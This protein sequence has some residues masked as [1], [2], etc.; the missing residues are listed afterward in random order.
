MVAHLETGYGQPDLLHDSDALVSEDPS[1]RHGGHVAL[2]DVEIGAADRGRRDADDGVRGVFDL[3]PR[4]VLPGA[5]PGPVKDESLHVHDFGARDFACLD[6]GFGCS[7]ERLWSN[8]AARDRDA[9]TLGGRHR[10]RGPA[11]LQF[12]GKAC[13]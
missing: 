8:P 13:R 1:R 5:P 9:W 10:F 4:C 2:E 11:R 6:E 12:A 7:H 3:G